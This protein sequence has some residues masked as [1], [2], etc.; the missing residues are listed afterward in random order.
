MRLISSTVVPIIQEPSS[1]GLFKHI[2]KVARVCYLSED[3]ITD[4][5]YIDMLEKLKKLG[6]LSPLEHGTVYLKCPIYYNYFFYNPY[7]IVYDSYVATNYRVLYESGRAAELMND[8]VDYSDIPDAPERFKRYTVKITCDIGVAREFCRHRVFSFM[9]EST[10]YCNY[11]T[12]GVTFILPYWYDKA[13][14]EKQSD[15]EECMSYYEKA[16]LRAIEAGQAPQAARCLLPLATKTT[17]IMTGFKEQWD[18]FFEA[19]FNV[20]AH[21]DAQKIAGTIKE[22]LTM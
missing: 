3:K 18:K 14:E 11:K 10:R 16:Y 7:S 19:R 6:H 12:K 17:L 21:P 8:M 1:E 22:I 5:S 15:F 4:S 9:Q 13:D 2:E 20:K